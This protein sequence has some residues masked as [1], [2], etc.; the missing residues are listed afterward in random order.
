ML[1]M[2]CP[3]RHAALA[4]WREV[5]LGLKRRLGVTS[6]EV[7]T[8]LQVSSSYERSC[9]RHGHDL[10]FCFVACPYVFE[11]REVDGVVKFPS[12]VCDV[13]FR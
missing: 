10:W 4:T 5:R 7:N 6:H 2:H 3:E 8:L 1:A 12:V 13:D 9:R 11:E